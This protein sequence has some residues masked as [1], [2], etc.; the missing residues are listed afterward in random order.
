M[1]DV[2]SELVDE[3][4]RHELELTVEELSDVLWLV[5][6]GFGAVTPKGQAEIAERVVGVPDHADTA[7][8]ARLVGGTDRQEAS[9]PM[10]TR[11]RL[12]RNERQAEW[13]R[14]PGELAEVKDRTQ[15]QGAAI[16]SEPVARAREEY[17]PALPRAR[18]IADALRPL[19]YSSYSAHSGTVL[20]EAET[21]HRSALTGIRLPVWQTTR[22]RRLDLDLV[23]DRG[24]SGVLC[25]RLA[26]ELRLLLEGHGAFRSV[27]SWTLDSDCAV[28]LGNGRAAAALRAGL[29]GDTLAMGRSGTRYPVGAVCQSPRRPVVMVVTDGT[30]GAWWAGTIHHVLREWGM[31]GKV[32]LIHVLPRTMWSGTALRPIP[33]T[34]LPAA[35]GYHRGTRVHADKTDLISLGL[36]PKTLSRTL[37][38][39]VVALDP[40]WLR[41]WVPLLRGDDVGEVEAYALLIAATSESSPTNASVPDRHGWPSDADQRMQRF[42]LIA[43]D[44]AFRLAWYLSGRQFTPVDIREIQR[45]LGPDSG[46]AASAEVLLGG[47]VRRSTPADMDT[48]PDNVVFEFHPEVRELLRE[49]GDPDRGADPISVAT[50]LASGV[51]G[52]RRAAMAVPRLE[53]E[54]APSPQQ[55]GGAY[56]PAS[57]DRERWP[58]APTEAHS[59]ITGSR[60]VQIA[61]WGAPQAGKSTYLTVLSKADWKPSRLGGLWRVTPAD[62]PT[63]RLMNASIE[64]L[65]RDGRFPDQTL[66]PSHLSFR[67]LRQ[68]SRLSWLL[69]ASREAEIGVSFTDRSGGDFNPDPNRLVGGPA[70]PANASAT[71]VDA[72]ALAT[73]SDADAFVYFFD[74]TYDM[75]DEAAEHSLN[76]FDAAMISLSRIMHA[77][78]SL[79]GPYLPQHMAV[80]ITKL[81]D[82]RVYSVARREGLMESRRGFDQ[83][84][85]PDKHARRLFEL[86]CQ[87]RMTT[88]A[89]YLLNQLRQR[90]H[91]K[92]ISYHVISSVGFWIGQS[93]GI[94]AK[95]PSNAVPGPANRGPF[96]EEGQGNWRVR[97]ETR[98]MNVL[99]PLVTLVQNAR[100]TQR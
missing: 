12:D 30:G 99:E 38:F 57:S 50:A 1:F 91:P 89:D 77:R 28:P 35:D 51:I 63:R 19:R 15:F 97:G 22:R 25:E 26:A 84:W 73:L 100:R 13:A 96:A 39:P 43:S 44:D 6:M 27:R 21:A 58:S 41:A 36:K 60:P 47:L 64:G 24:G 93:G 88:E 54:A 68:R 20:D 55:A 5:R 40:A 46:L 95:E 17:T 11:E 61:L 87:A 23:F 86:I 74:P 9:A 70:A 7:S 81:D 59:G 52:R 31:Y 78:G 33:V 45:K 29:P 75:D 37:A 67:L 90:F 53:R 66:R 34:F 42:L 92:R 3:L 16:Q 14:M 4:R 32:L 71:G 82:R 85:V 49:F 98:P 10:P 72:D 2:L 76:F 94:N 69:R 65:D 79:L 56:A 18:A 80:Y 48:P 62:A 8:M 83:P